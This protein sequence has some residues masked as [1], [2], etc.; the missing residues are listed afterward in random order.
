VR[1]SLFLS[2][3]THA[4][5]IVNESE[6]ETKS[7]NP[8]PSGQIEQERLCRY[9]SGNSQSLFPADGQPVTLRHS[10]SVHH[11]LT[12]RHLQPGMAVLRNFVNDLFT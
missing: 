10:L 12:A 8:H 7:A 2:L 4:D 5:F 6:T 3:H 9:V 1:A 11:N